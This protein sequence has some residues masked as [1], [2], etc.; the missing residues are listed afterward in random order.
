[1]KVP[2]PFDRELDVRGETCPGP[3]V[4]AKRTV[5]ELE[6]GQVLR[7]LATD[8]GSVNDFRSWTQVDKTVELVAQE[9][10]TVNGYPVY[11]HYIKRIA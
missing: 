1:M 7:V 6:V 3:I 5:R 11:V 2:L 4:K 8:Y 9:T 10:E